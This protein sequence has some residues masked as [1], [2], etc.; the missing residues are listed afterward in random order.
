M[1]VQVPAEPVGFAAI[2]L[3]AGESTRMGRP[4]PLLPWLGTTLVAYQVEQLVRAGAKP[5][6]V[7]L[8]HER[9][10]VAEA[11]RDFPEAV[12][13]PNPRY[14]QGKTSSIRI[15]AGALAGRTGAI[16]LHAVDQP[17]RWQTLR[18]LIYAHC[19]GGYP[20]TIPSHQG[21]RGHPPVLSPSL[22]PELESLSEETQGLRALMRRHALETQTVPMETPECLLNANTPED[23]R[24]ALAYFEALASSTR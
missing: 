7:V 1:Q 18:L 15:G 17:R 24:E 11:L 10:F 23:Y 14:S 12:L 4:K 8:G 5:L 6:I 21:R 16:L 22:L 9:E 3:A 20:I 2:L 19:G 13:V